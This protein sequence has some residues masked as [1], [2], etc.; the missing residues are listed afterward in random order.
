MSKRLIV[1]DGDF[2]PYFVGY[3]KKDQP[4]KTLDQVIDETNSIMWNILTK[5]GATE[6]IG[7]LGVKGDKTFRHTIY[8]EYK[9]KRNTEPPPFF[10]EVRKHLVSYWK[11][12][13]GPEGIETDDAV[14]IT[15]LK[16]KGVIVS[17]D[18]DLLQLEGLHFNARKMS[19]VDNTLLN[20]QE[21]YL[22]WKD[23]LT[24]QTGDNVKGVPGV[25]EKNASRILQN[26][27][28]TKLDLTAINCAYAGEV[29]KVY[30]HYFG[31]TKGIKEFQ[32]NY[33][34]LK[35]LDLNEEFTEFEIPTPESFDVD[36]FILKQLNNDGD[37]ETRVRE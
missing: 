1:I 8:P 36:E 19:W 37:L 28:T 11:F 4:E 26:I 9:G 22:F 15:R 3:T 24:G 18:K 20:E 13:F 30:T 2:I 35:I 31:M 12:R 34:C 17:H 7:F 5:T 16:L 14:N 10:R 32:K 21:I 33:T 6:Y 23:M 27:N 25:G 29:L